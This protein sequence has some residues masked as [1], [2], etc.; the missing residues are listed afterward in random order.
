MNALVTTTRTV[1]KT[2]I[3]KTALEQF[4]G[5]LPLLLIILGMFIILLV[6]VKMTLKDESTSPMMD[7]DLSNN[8]SN[9]LMRQIVKESAFYYKNNR[10]QMIAIFICALISCFAGLALLIFSA[11]YF[12]DEAKTMGIIGGIIINFISSIIFWIYKQCSKQVQCDF[13]TLIHLQNICLAIELINDCDDEIQNRKKEALIDK[14]LES[15]RFLYS[16]KEE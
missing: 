7:C 12:A 15:S 6:V 1:T 5:M 10:R 8:I 9:Q 2:P 3:D 13:N 11:L 4:I 16:G 14:L